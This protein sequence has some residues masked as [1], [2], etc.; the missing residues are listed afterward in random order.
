MPSAD[1][2]AKHLEERRA[3]ARDGRFLGIVR[4]SRPDNLWKPEKVFAL[5]EP[6]RYAPES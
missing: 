1:V 3:Y 4:F 6:S 5:S 2:Y